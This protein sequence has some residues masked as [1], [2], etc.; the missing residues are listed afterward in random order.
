[1]KN[2]KLHASPHP[3]ESVAACPEV[4]DAEEYH[5]SMELGPLI[6]ARIHEEIVPCMASPLQGWSIH[7]A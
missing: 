2:I 1:M 5:I 4:W 3:T 7:I 6:D